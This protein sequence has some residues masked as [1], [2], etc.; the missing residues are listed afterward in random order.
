MQ[1]GYG[2]LF[3]IMDVLVDDFNTM[4]AKSGSLKTPRKTLFSSITTLLPICLEILLLL[5]RPASLQ[6]FGALLKT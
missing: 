3:L 2:L 6:L 1:E 5:Q 4:I